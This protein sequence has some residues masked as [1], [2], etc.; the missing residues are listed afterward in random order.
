MNHK[1]IFVVI[2][3]WNGMKWIK[4]CLDALRESTYP[5][6]TVVV[7]NDSKDETVS[8]IQNN[9]P[10]I[11]IIESEKN[12][13]FGQANNV[14]LRYALANDCDYVYLLN[15]D[16]YVYPDMFQYLIQEAEKEENKKKFAIYSPIHINGDRKSLD[17][18]FRNYIKDISPY[19]VEDILLSHIKSIYLVGC[20]P[21]AGW[22]LPR[23]TLDTIGGFDPLFFHYGED[24]NYCQ[25]VNF[26]GYKI[27]FV[28][29]AKMVHDRIIFGNPEVYKKGKIARRIDSYITLNVN[30]SKSTILK[31][32]FKE[33]VLLII[34][35]FKGNPRNIVDFICYLIRLTKKF[36][37]YKK[38][39]IQN[40][41]IFSNWL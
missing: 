34:M 24:V 17:K 35:L 14:G 25:R 38:S 28:P 3:T 26:H 31:L 41:R 20:V 6:K 4:R 33:F 13:G 5:V 22:L 8:F 19:I 9:Y 2:V 7:D 30:N 36:K 40:K 11:H 15:Q 12:L 29:M 23:K 10:E 32:L 18:H 27:G 16:A 37:E 1:S 39:R 21:A